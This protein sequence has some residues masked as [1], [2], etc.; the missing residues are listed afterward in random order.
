MIQQL[1]PHKTATVRRAKTLRQWNSINTSMPWIQTIKGH[2]YFVTDQGQDWTPIGQNDAITW[3]ELK[4]VFR[5]KDLS[6]AEN[7]I[8][9]LAQKGVT[10]MRLM[11][12]YCQREHRYLEAPVGNFQPNMVHMWDDIFTLCERYSIRILLTPFD[13]FWMWIRWNHHPYRK[14]NGG[15]CDKR[16][17]WLLCKTTRAAIKRRLAFATQ[18]WGGSGALFGWDLWNEIHPA[19]AGNEATIFAD[20]VD[21]ISH[22]LR[23]TELRLHGRAHP[24]TVSVFGPVLK[25]DRLVVDC[26]FRH[27]SL[28]FASVHF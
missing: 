1:H 10:C 23:Q 17:E 6:T 27:P 16:G 19:H 22:F 2:P 7:Y 13:T 21:D 12:E 11:L 28:D 9:M 25:N 5:R 15:H 4:G 26:A 20:F 24:Q 8:A 3:P 14:T 18:R